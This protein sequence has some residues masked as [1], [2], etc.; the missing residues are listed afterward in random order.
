MMVIVAGIGMDG[1]IIAR[2]AFLPARVATLSLCQQQPAKVVS[3][4]RQ[5]RVCKCKETID[6]GPIAQRQSRGLI[7]PWLQVRILL[8]PLAYDYSG[9]L[10][11]NSPS[12]GGWQPEHLLVTRSRL[13]FCVYC[14]ATKKNFDRDRIPPRNL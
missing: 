9:F 12:M 8:G 5:R 1:D 14:G 4:R 7:I 13:E 6:D 2:F 11:L 10:S 3:E